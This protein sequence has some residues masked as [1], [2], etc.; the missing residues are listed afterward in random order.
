MRY[1]VTEGAETR[2]VEIRELGPNEFEVRVDDGDPVRVDVAKSPRTVYSL[3]I[4][5]R[6]FEGSADEGRDGVLDVRVGA[7]AFQFKVIDERRKLLAVS[8]AHVASGRQELRA[9]MPGKIVKLLVEVGQQVERDQALV[10]IEA[11][12]MENELKSP[13]DG[14]VTVLQVR[15]GETVEANA[16]LAVIEPP[17]EEG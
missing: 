8:A 2:R 4:D 1:E 11:M 9:Q 17:G 7:S 5:G 10:V 6:Q 14:V 12:K 15:E 13:V 3:L 16:L